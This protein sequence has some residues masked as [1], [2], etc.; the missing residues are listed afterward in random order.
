MSIWDNE[1]LDRPAGKSDHDAQRRMLAEK[2]A[3]EKEVSQQQQQRGYVGAGAPPVQPASQGE[4]IVALEQQVE[5]TSFLL[6]VL[7]V[8][9]ERLKPVLLPSAPESTG[10]KD[11][12]Y[13]SYSSQV[14]QVAHVTTVRITEARLR[15]ETLLQL[16]AL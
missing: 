8:L 11:G 7:G 2:A 10:K 13:R 15:I 3:F 1:R 14:A 12:V 5:E 9:S 16:L 4:I 6:D